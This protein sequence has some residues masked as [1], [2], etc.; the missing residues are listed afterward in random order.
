MTRN[1]HGNWR[2]AV[3]AAEAA[4][5][6]RGEWTPEL[7][8]ERLR[9]AAKIAAVCVKAPYPSSKVV[10][11]LE[12]WREYCPEID[13]AKTR[14]KTATPQQISMMEETLVWMAEYVKCN[15]ARAMLSQLAA[16]RTLGGTFRAVCKARGWGKTQAYE[17]CN[18]NLRIIASALNRGKVTLRV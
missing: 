4:S 12:T 18:L 7:V 11:T 2:M 5:D 10:A 16:A 6:A 17:I 13:E 8:L 1:W 14:R 15:K 9:Q 3:S